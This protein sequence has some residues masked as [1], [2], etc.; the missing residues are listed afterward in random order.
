MMRQI[1]TRLTLTL[2]TIGLASPALAVDGVIEINHARVLAGGVTPSDTAGYPATLDRSGSYR[3]TGN[4]SVPD[5]NTTGIEIESDDVT[6]DLNGFAIIGSVVCSGEPVTSCSPSFGTGNGIYA[7]SQSQITVRNGFVR[8]MGA[9]GIAISRSST[10]IE[11]IHASHNAGTG[12]SQYGIGSTITG[13]IAT[14]NGSKG[15]SVGY[16]TVADN[17]ALY[18]GSDGMFVSSGSVHGNTSMRNGG[19]GI[20]AKNGITVNGNAFESNDGYGLYFLTYVANTTGGYA[21]NSM[22]NNTGGTVF[23]AGVQTGTNVCNGN[24]TCP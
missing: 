2:L 5:A 7:Y 9:S 14:K 23:G 16:A 10:R 11:G 3:L 13:N 21:N 6:V 17:V 15:I 24:T 20:V 1:V 4:L 18:N 19:N 8:G 22:N 12:I